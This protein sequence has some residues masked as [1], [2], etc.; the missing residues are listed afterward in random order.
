MRSSRF[1][2]ALALALL[3]VAATGGWRVAAAQS[4]APRSVEDLAYGEVLFH[5]YQ[6]DYFSALVRL[7]SAQTRAEFEAHAG[8]AE[9]LSGGL[10]L[11]YGQHR[12]A[13]EIFSAV[14]EQS[15]DP[16]L[17]DRA[18]YFLANIWHQRGYLDES[19]AALGRISGALPE[20]LELQRRMLH[21][22]VAMEQGRFNEALTHL[23]AWPE[24]KSQS[25]AYAKYN[26]GVALVRLGEVAAGAGVLQEVG[27]L[28]I[29]NDPDFF[30]LRDRANV[31]LGY[32]W[33]QAEAP[34]EAKA[35]LQ[36]V[37]MD[38]PFSNKALLGVGWS[39]AE[40]SDYQAALAPWV[41][42]H[43]RDLLDS[44]VQESLLAVPYAYA[45]LGAN[46]QAVAHYGE[47]IESFT[48][49][50]ARLDAAIGAIR[51]GRLLSTLLDHG[52]ADGSGWYW[53]LEQ[54]PDTDE[55]R[56]LYELMSTHRFQEALKNYRDLVYLEQNLEGW[57]QSL[58]A[59]DD[60][61][62]TRERA[63]SER[64]P[65]VDSSLANVDTE[66]MSRQRV[67]LE[68]RLVSIEREEDFVALGTG[69]EQDAWAA[70]MDVE[71]KLE[72][73][74]DDETAESLRHKQR[75]LKG[76]LMWDLEKVYKERLWRQRRALDE[77]TREIRTAE[78]LELRVRNARETWPSQFGG[79]SQRVSELQARVS[80]LTGQ[81]RTG[82][83][84]QR[85]YLQDIAVEELLAKRQRL[86][87]YL[88]QAQF[89]LAAIYDRAAMNTSDLAPG[90]VGE[91]LAESAQ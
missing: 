24:K 58:E 28:R 80:M 66:A 56:Y 84:N 2:S 75:V 30:A 31:A 88:V 19:A 57:T 73:L 60:I 8:D 18:W 37:R 70:L 76:V 86:G 39:D 62:A 35:S 63:Y 50:I 48:A 42:L 68:S 65:V 14:L 13:G 45:Q 85:A 10:Y 43:G 82:I 67:M 40:L 38:G 53:R 52:K 77:A 51:D 26:I 9:L 23:D 34:A 20:D 71:Q 11:S 89:S 44:A 16:A 32:A 87:T 25:I 47:A 61:L 33:L 3:T 29:R 91:V 17:H 79:Q 27:E 54:V 46:A 15:A 4:M 59:F 78:R 12:R 41:E 7:L 49:E 36:R 55:S 21:A 90:S 22:Q 64:R 74:G 81:T 72:L 5:F 69:A 6:E 1:H 83:A